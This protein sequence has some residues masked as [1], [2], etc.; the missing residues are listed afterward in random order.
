MYLFLKVHVQV[1]IFFIMYATTLFTEI[2]YEGSGE[3][4]GFADDHILY[5]VF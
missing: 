2:S 3:L 5:D 4:F 1:H